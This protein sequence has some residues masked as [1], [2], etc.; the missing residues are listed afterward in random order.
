MI[1]KIIHLCWFS[2]DPYPVEIKV[3]LDTWK[4]L[5]PDYTI[6]LWDYAAAKAIGCDFVNEALETRKWAFAADAVRFYAVFTEGG[7]YM[8]SDIY[9]Y[10]RFDTFMEAEC[11]TTFMT[12]EWTTKSGLQA[13]FFLAPKADPYCKDVW[14]YYQSHHFRNDDG[15]FNATIS[16]IIMEQVA[17]SYG[18]DMTN[19]NTQLLESLYVYPTTF[20]KP[21]KKYPRTENT[22]A[23]HRIFGSWRKRKLSRKIDMKVIHI[24]NVIKY[25]L[26][27]R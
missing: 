10:K 27:K 14:A 5:L 13:A 25:A 7:V 18:F 4:K 1:P 17:A 9:L 23:E 6:R 19:R 8:D 11:F 16:P 22:F 2:K 26:F 21:R 3:C 12:E 15:S 24:W 20:L